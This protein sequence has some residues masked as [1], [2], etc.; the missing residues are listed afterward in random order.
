[1]KKLFK[2]TIEKKQGMVLFGVLI[3]MI[4]AISLVSAVSMW[5]GISY[6]NSKKT[7]ASDK[8]FYIAEAGIDYAKWHDSW[9]TTS[10]TYSKDLRNSQNEVVGSF[11][12]NMTATEIVDVASSTA[13]TTQITIESTG[14]TDEYPYIQRKIR[15]D[16]V[17][18]STTESTNGYKTINWQEIK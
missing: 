9:A 11:V 3:F 6:K 10:A 14:Y 18:T 16:L 7:L 12:I 17:V 8:A 4:M 1:M 13:S 15:L 2:K 5:F